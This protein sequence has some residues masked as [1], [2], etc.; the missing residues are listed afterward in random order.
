MAMDIK[1]KL[2]STL[3]TIT[4]PDGSTKPAIENQ[5]ST[6]GAGHVAD[7][8]IAGVWTSQVFTASG[9][10]GSISVPSGAIAVSVKFNDTGSSILTK[11][12]VSISANNTTEAEAAID[13][14][15]AG[16]A[17]DAEQV[18]INDKLEMSFNPTNSSTLIAWK[19]TGTDTGTNDVI[20][21][22]K[23]QA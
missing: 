2:E 15:F 5:K 16:S 20:V 17:A 10:L 6:G 7:V 3:E 23:V 9:T 22:Y 18:D 11:I 14:L 19:S 1:V 4:L 12:G 8:G 13:A 21:S